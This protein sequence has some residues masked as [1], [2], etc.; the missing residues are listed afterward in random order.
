MR[1]RRTKCLCCGHLYRADARNRGRQRYCSKPDCQRASKARSQRRW[2]QKPENQNYFRDAENAARVRGWQ[3]SHP[4]YWRQTTRYKHHT[5]QDACRTQVVE[6]LKDSA[7]LA[8]QE[9]LRLQTPVLLGLIATLTDSTLQEDMVAA[10]RRLLQLGQDI[11]SG[12]VSD[13]RQTG[14]AP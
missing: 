12:N 9:T 5:L 4:G 2:L 11:L 1:K 13:A 6:P 14:A 10:S 3:G 7:L 8:L